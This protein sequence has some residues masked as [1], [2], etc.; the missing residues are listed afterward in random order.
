MR[1]LITTPQKCTFCGKVVTQSSMV[2]INRYLGHS[3]EYV[4]SECV[5]SI[6]SGVEVTVFAINF[7]EPPKE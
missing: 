2:E 4:C 5:N 7:H 3:G 1:N 6:R